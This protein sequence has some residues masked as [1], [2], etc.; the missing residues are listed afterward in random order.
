MAIPRWAALAMAGSMAAVLAGC[1]SSSGS[2]NNTTTTTASSKAPIEI[3]MVSALTG[4]NA[5]SGHLKVD[6]AQLAINQI[7]AQGGVDGRKLKLI[8]EDDQSTNPGTVAAFEKLVNSYPDLVAVIGPIR[9]TEMQ[10]ITPLV[11]QYKIPVLEGG[12]DPTITHEGDP[13]VFRFRPND[14]YSGRTMAY[15]LTQVL[16][17]KNIAIVHSTDAFGEGG[18]KALTQWLKTYGGNVVTDQGYTN[19]AT[20]YTA[21]VEAIKKANPDAVAT[22]FTF[23]PDLAI[24]LRQMNQL[25]V[26]TTILGSPSITATDV[27]NLLHSSLDGDYGVTDY[28]MGQNP[29]AEAFGKAFQATYNERPDNY[30]SYTWDAVRVLAH[31]LQPILKKGNLTATQIHQEVRQGMLSVRNFPAAEAPGQYNFDQNG[32]GL[33]GYTVVQYQNGTLKILGAYDFYNK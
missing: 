11:E 6:G 1:G 19:G 15:Y 14:N 3:G 33:Q 10:A 23:G 12:T 22:Y 4:E 24:F 18:D 5:L 20:D 16:H 31:V 29:T 28:V 21:I 30:S 25:G 8:V 27:V 13:W 32:D 17:K 7:N 26:H 2:G 9:S